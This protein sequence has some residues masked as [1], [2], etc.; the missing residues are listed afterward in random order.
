SATDKELVFI[1]R[2]SVL[3]VSLVALAISWEKNSTILDLVGYA[4]AGFGAAFGPLI[5]FSLYW[6]RMTRWGALA[7]MVV[8]AAT[9]II[10]AN[11]GLSKTLY[12]MI[13]GF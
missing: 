2:I 5:L 8:G 9:V 10:W 11:V 6:R 13:P 1:G 3:V 12:E 7:G 4:W